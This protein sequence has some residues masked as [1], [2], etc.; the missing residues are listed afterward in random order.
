MLPILFFCRS[1]RLLH[2]SFFSPSH[3]RLLLRVIV[4]RILLHAGFS[5]Y[6]DLAYCNLYVI[7]VCWCLSIDSFSDSRALALLWCWI[8][9]YIAQQ[10]AKAVIAAQRHSISMTENFYWFFFSDRISDSYEPYHIAKITFFRLLW[11]MTLYNV[12]WFAIC[13]IS[14]CVILLYF[15]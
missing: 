7:F 11:Q 1:S 14:V 4:V 3:R 12:H 8:Y 6:V 10:Q 15:Y 9:L 5:L 2:A 13:G